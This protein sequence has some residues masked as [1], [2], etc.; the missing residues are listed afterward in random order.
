MEDRKVLY[1]TD[2]LHNEFSTFTTEPPYIDGNY[3]YERRSGIKKFM[4]FFLYRIVMYPIVVLYALIVF[5]QKIVGKKKLKPFKG[6]GIFLYGN[7]TQPLGDALLQ[8][9][10]TFPRRTYIIVHPNNLKVPVF[11]KMVPA[12]GGLPI[13]DDKAAYKNF[14]AAVNGRVSEGNP[15]VIYPEAHIWPYYTGIRPFVDT[16]FLYPVNLQAPV[17]CFVNTYKKTRFRKRPK[18]VTYI[19]G[20]FYPE[21]E[22]SPKVNRKRL[23]D[24]VYA[25]MCELASNSDVNV[26]EY[27]KKEEKN[28]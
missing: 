21:K 4:N 11:G 16:S 14:L 24:K 7:H 22:G 2:E 28:G 13:P 3:D 25:C 6:K 18:M 9:R 23:R 20:P 26:I 15:L 8:T 12:L 5:R 19:E 1:Y 17:F 27:I 10:L